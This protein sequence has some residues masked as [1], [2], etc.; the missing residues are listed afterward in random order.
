VAAVLTAI[1]DIVIPQ[2]DML[3]QRVPLRFAGG[4][5]AL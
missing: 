2:L 5:E 1:R 4:Q 3:V